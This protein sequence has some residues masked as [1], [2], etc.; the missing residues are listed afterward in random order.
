MNLAPHG[1]YVASGF[2]R[3]L[4]QFLRCLSSISLMA[5][6][7]TVLSAPSAS[8]SLRGVYVGSEFYAPTTDWQNAAYNSKFTALFLFTLHVS[9]NGD[10]AYNST[11]VVQ[12]GTFIGDPTWGSKLAACRG[13]GGSI[14]RIEICVGNWGSTSFDHIRDLIA[15]Q[16]TGTGSI[17]YRNF[18][19]LKNATGVDAVQFDDEKTYHVSSAVAFGNM[20]ASMGLKVT[21]VPFT[22]QSFWVN[23]KSQLGSKVDHIYLQCYDGGAGN[24]PAQWTSAFGGF[25]VDPGLWGNT[26]TQASAATKFRNWQLQ[27]GIKGGFM[28]LNGHMPGDAPNWGQA[29]INGLDS[30]EAENL[31]INDAS[32]LVDLVTDSRYSNG[33]ADILR[34]G[35]A[36]D[37]VTYLVPN[38]P[39][40]TYTVSVIMKKT[41]V[42][43]QFQLSASRAD[44]STWS[45]IG[46]V[47]DEYSSNAGGDFVEV[48]VG[49]W[50]PGTTN[51]K[52]FKFTVTG[53]N[54][55]SG[56]YW[57]SVD[58]LRLKKQ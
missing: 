6:A 28:W 27:I 34:A 12:N 50:S 22:A 5:L 7:I 19:A 15:S 39:A 13:G 35:A 52:L 47:I 44:L 38:I 11:P 51:D 31:S 53:K 23:V 25:V 26:D 54:P 48:N 56:Q 49:T 4:A 57:I 55:S 8:A 46:P 40:G 36:G 24:N 30:F 32:D 9:P 21:L 29:V 16:G 45:N 17:L 20:L 41:N 58:Y 2:P 1:Q 42:R 33:Q 18:L 10:L 14:N 3:P 43:G 37:S